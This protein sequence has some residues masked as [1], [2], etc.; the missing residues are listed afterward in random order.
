MAQPAG[1][2]GID[3]ASIDLPSDDDGESAQPAATQAETSDAS[4]VSVPAAMA[5]DA[6]PHRLEL[7]NDRGASYRLWRQR[8]DDYAMLAGLA[9]KPPALQ[10]AILRTCLSDEA[11]TVVAN[12]D[13]PEAQRNDIAAV[14]ARLEQYARGQINEVIQRRTFNICEQANGESF[15]DFVTRLRDLS[16]DCGFCDRCRES[17][18]RDRIVVGLRDPGTIKRLCAVPLLTLQQAIQICRSEEAASRDVTAIVGSGADTVSSCT[19]PPQSG[20]T[21]CRSQPS[22][23]GVRFQSRSPTPPRRQ[24]GAG[25]TGFQSRSPTPPRRPSGADATESEP[26][27]TVPPPTC[28]NCGQRHVRSARCPAAGRPCYNCGRLGHISRMCRSPRH[29]YES[30]ASA[31]TMATASRGSA[32]TVRVFVTG[33]RTAEMEALP[34]T[35]ADVSVAGLDF[36]PPIDELNDNLQPPTTHPRAVDGHTVR[37]RGSLPVQIRLGDVTVSDTV[38]IIPGVPRLLLSWKTAQ[39]LRLIPTD[40]PEQIASVAIPA[41]TPPQ[42]PL[43]GVGCQTAVHRCT[44]A[45]PDQPP[46]TAEPGRCSPLAPPSARSAPPV[47]PPASVGPRT[48]LPAASG[49]PA[50]A[51]SPLDEFPDVLDGVIRAMPGE[52]FRIHLREDATPFAVHAPRRIPLSLREPLRLELDKLERDG[53]ITPVTAPTEWCSPIVVTPKRES[54]GVRLCVDLSQ[55]NKAVKRELYQSNTPAECAASITASEA[56]WF[57]VFDAAKGYHQCPLAEASRP[58]TTFITPFGRYQYLRAPYGVS[59]ISEHYNRRMDECFCGMDGIQRVVDDVI[60]YSKT[61]K[62]HVARVREFLS[63]CRA[64]GVSLNPSKTQHMQSSVKF[65]GFSISSEG[66]TPDPALTEAIA[67]FPA[68]QSLTDLRSF[69][70]LVNQVAPFSE[71]IAELMEPLRPLLSSRR[72]FV[73]D[74]CHEAAFAAA[75]AALSSVRTL[76]YFDQTRPTLLTTDA[77]RLKGIGFL[78]QQKQ[79]DGTWRVIQAGSRFLTDAESRYATIELE[80]LAVAWAVRKCRLFL[81]GLPHLDLVVDHRPLVPI[82]NRKNLDEIENP[83]LQRLREKISEVNITASW[84][85]GKEH[86]AAD[87]LSRAPVARPTVGDE[88]AEDC[89]TPAVLTV[90]ACALS[91]SC[92]DLRLQQVREAADRDEEARV[93]LDTV[94]HGFPAH[95]S[96]LPEII[97]AYWPVHDQLSV[98]DGLVVYGCRIVVP[99]PLR[100]DILRELHASHMGKEKTKQRARQVVFWPNMTNDIE[101]VTRACQPCQR[102]L[103]SLPKETLRVHE[104]PSRPFQHLCADFCQHA[105]HYFLVTVDPLSGWLTVCPVGRHASASTLIRELRALFCLT[106]APE[107]FWSDGGP[108]F[109]STV[110]QAFLTNWAVQHRTSS[111]HYAQSNGR[112]EAAVKFAAKLIRRCWRNGHLD[113]DSWVRG[114]LQHRNTPGPDGRSP[115][116]ILFHAPTRDALPAHRR[117][118]AAEW[119][120]AADEIERAAAARHRHTREAYNQHARDLPA[121]RVGSQVALQDPATGLWDRH[122][123]VTDVG[124]HRRYFIRLP[125]GRVLTRNRRH[126]R[127]RY[128]HAT[129]DQADTAPLPGSPPAAAATAGPQQSPQQPQPPPASP[130]AAQQQSQSPPVVPVTDPPV[131]LPRRSERA[132]R[133]PERFIATM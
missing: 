40:Y 120:R 23:R 41:P 68:P 24:S 62:E 42:S 10:M 65:A 6:K 110:F 49:R 123:V 83:R 48:A 124:P 71:E 132:R 131:M 8:W 46:P 130:V 113:N 78:L 29:A 28:R 44:T 88:L 118:F 50:P 99:R 72:T 75:R 93:L 106:G 12:F 9:G 55:L 100:A 26:G 53:V 38:H 111:P 1:S 17:L 15:D 119:Q 4:A 5:R 101:N 103:P 67:S 43:P 16:R 60:V 47:P 22:R 52:E 94:L 129:P 87:A 19:A 14:L 122:G 85:P 73:W 115:A 84:R 39:A 13:T 116:Q 76:A 125:S 102:E 133:K 45:T 18:I 95:K 58:L 70:G 33:R 82:I 81:V 109:T 91:E 34:D 54:S 35:G 92:M 56:K 117:S 74:S 21:R 59:S 79:T 61:K 64:Q 25:A 63:R 11:L 32:P 126:L 89:T 77:S 69:F 36:A 90:F 107:V 51:D 80:L 20:V 121:F 128:A 104:Q 108:Q 30:S 97:R 114:M 7:I 105:G 127:Q 66:Y 112:A 31:V 57:S 2:A 37:S 96:E 98:D 3:P 86:S 27:A